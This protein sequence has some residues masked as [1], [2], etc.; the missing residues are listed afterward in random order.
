MK[1]LKIKNH[2]EKNPQGIPLGGLKQSVPFSKLLAGKASVIVMVLVIVVWSSFLI[3]IV[4]FDKS[5]FPQGESCGNV[6]GV[7]TIDKKLLRAITEDTILHEVAGQIYVVYDGTRV[8]I[9]ESE[10]LGFL[11]KDCEISAEDCEVRM[12]CVRVELVRDHVEGCL[13]ALF[14]RDVRFSTAANSGG[15]FEYRQ[16]DFGPDMNKLVADI[17]GLIEMRIAGYKRLYCGDSE[18]GIMDAVGEPKEQENQIVISNVE[19]L[20]T[21]GSFA[22]KYIEIDHSQQH[23]Y[24]WEDGEV[25][26]DYD[27]SGFYD[28]YA[29]FGVFSVIDKSLN[30]WSPVAE[31]WMPFWMAFYYAPDQEAWFGIHE[32]VYWHDDDG[33]YHE[34]SSESIG[35]QKSGG[36]VRLDRG[37]AE[38]LYNMIEVD[39][40]V[41]LHP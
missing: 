27:V 7:S 31:K 24:V 13:E 30:A 40:P 28:E 6:A 29:V 19:Y 32:L 20:G 5:D 1:V 33:T 34:E 26:Y 23:L 2:A 35:L 12:P 3:R 25:T 4:I 18:L 8:V 10:V 14:T 21:N 37:E 41:L 39:T 36:C 11:K 16:D 9:S 22:Q 15:T 17:A 38:E